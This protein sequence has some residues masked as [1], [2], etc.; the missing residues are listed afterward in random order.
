MPF[1]TPGYVPG[2]NTGG[3]KTTPPPPPPVSFGGTIVGAIQTYV[4][5]GNTQAV[6]G[7]VGGA[8]AGAGGI[9]GAAGTV[10]GVI[11]GSKP[12]A[13]LDLATGA[14][15]GA[16]IGSVIPGVGT[17]IGGAVG[18]VAGIIGIPLGSK[19]NANWRRS[20]GRVFR[21]ALLG[22]VPE[23]FSPDALRALYVLIQAWVKSGDASG[24]KF[25]DKVVAYFKIPTAGGGTK[26][27][28][29]SAAPVGEKDAE[30]MPEFK[31]LVP[32]LTAIGL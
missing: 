30:K 9:A 14:T 20:M 2:L 26:H 21:A 6:L 24:A 31:Q 5:G 15:L 11:A 16:T 1:F 17:V 23:V 27:G 13:Q 32:W 8:L 22:Y 29:N 28:F 12:G 18:A 4:S 7:S 25:W 10:L 3:A 19:S